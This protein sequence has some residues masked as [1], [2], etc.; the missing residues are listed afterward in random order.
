MRHLLITLLLCLFTFS[1]SAQTLYKAAQVEFEKEEYSK[2]VNLIK[3]SI[4]KEDLPYT[5][6]AAAFQLLQKS[7]YMQGLRNSPELDELLED[8]I[9]QNKTKPLQLISVAKIYTSV[10]PAEGFHKRNII[11]RST[12]SIQQD[13]LS[14]STKLAL[15]QLKKEQTYF[16]DLAELSVYFSQQE[17][18]LDPEKQEEYSYEYKKSTADY[19]ELLGIAQLTRLKILDL[20]SYNS[21]CAL[22]TLLLLE[23]NITQYD[24]AIQSYYWK[25]FTEIIQPSDSLTSTGAKQDFSFQTKGI[26]TPTEKLSKLPSYRLPE[27]L[28]DAQNDGERWRYGLKKLSDISAKERQ[29]S[30]FIQ[31][32]YYY[33]LDIKNRA[34]VL[35]E[36]SN[37]SIATLKQLAKEGHLESHWLLGTLYLERNQREKA[38]FYF[39]ESLKIKDH[40]AAKIALKQIIGNWGSF[41]YR[42][43][44]LKDS[45][46]KFIYRNSPYVD[47]TIR[48]VD[49]KK[50]F[51]SIHDHY[52]NLLGS[53]HSIP[54]N[55]TIDPHS[56]AKP[57]QRNIDF[58]RKFVLNSKQVRFPLDPNTEHQDKIVDIDLKLSRG[59]S[60]LVEAQMPNGNKTASFIYLPQNSITL[61]RLNSRV[62]IYVCDRFTG[63]PV[64]NK[65]V[66]LCAYQ[67]KKEDPDSF[68]E[69]NKRGS[70]Q[71]LIGRSDKDGLIFID[72]AQ[73][74][75]LET[76]KFWISVEDQ[77]SYDYCDIGSLKSHLLD[78]Y[79]TDER[80]DKSL[81]F[82][83]HSS[84]VATDKTHYKPGETLKF[85][86]WDRAIKYEP[87][88]TLQ[89][90]YKGD[91]LWQKR[92]EVQRRDQSISGEYKIPTNASSGEYRI[93]SDSGLK[94]YIGKAKE[95]SFIPKLAITK[96]PTKSDGKLILELCAQYPNGQ[97][98][99][100]AKTKIQLD[101]YAK[102]LVQNSPQEKWS[103]LYGQ[104]Y[105]HESKMLSSEAYSS[106]FRESLY[107][108]LYKGSF[109][110][111][112]QSQ[113]KYP[114]LLKKYYSVTL[115]E[116]GIA[117]IALD[118]SQIDFGDEL[119]AHAKIMLLSDS[120]NVYNETSSV[121]IASP[122][123]RYELRS[124]KNFYL[125]D[126]EIKITLHTTGQSSDEQHFDLSS[127]SSKLSFKIK[128]DSAVALQDL[129][130]G[131]YQFEGKT[132]FTVLD[133]NKSLSTSDKSLEIT[134]ENKTYKEGENAK[135]LI[136][137]KYKNAKVLFIT[138]PSYIGSYR[139]ENSDE[140]TEHSKLRLIQLDGFTKMLNLTVLN[141]DYP[142]IN[143][144]AILIK[145]GDFH[146][147][148]YNIPVPPSHKEIKVSLQSDKK[149]YKPGQKAKLKIK[150]QSHNNQ[151]ISSPITLSVYNKD[152][153]ESNRRPSRSQ[154][155]FKHLW[156]GLKTY[157]LN[158][159]TNTMSQGMWVNAVEGGLMSSL[160]STE[161]MAIPSFTNIDSEGF[162]N[163]IWKPLNI[164]KKEPK[165]DW[166]DV[167]DLAQDLQE[168]ARSTPQQSSKKQHRKSH[169]EN[170]YWN[171]NLIP[172]WRGEVTVEFTLP[173]TLS[174]WKIK[175]W[176]LDEELA[177]GEAELEIVTTKDLSIRTNPP[178]FLVEGD[179]ILYSANM[180]NS[181]DL[182]QEMTVDIK[183]SD[184]L[185]FINK[186]ETKRKVIIPAKTEAKVEWRLKAIKNGSAKVTINA[187]GKTD[188]DSIEE[189]FPIKAS[190][191]QKMISF[192]GSVEKT[193]PAKSF[194]FNVPNDKSELKITITPDLITTLVE[195]LPYLINH[196]HRNTE[197][198]LNS[199][200]STILI[201]DL[202][203][204]KE[205]KVAGSKDLYGQKTKDKQV[206]IEGE[207][208]D[209]PTYTSN[210]IFDKKHLDEL[211]KKG[212][213]KL[214]DMKNRGGGWP[215]FKG[216]KS[217]PY[218]TALI[219]NGLQKISSSQR[220]LSEHKGQERASIYLMNLFHY[221]SAD[222]NDE[223]AFITYLI[224]RAWIPPQFYEK[225]YK[226]RNR[227]STYSRCLIALI[228]DDAKA[229][230]ILAE[231]KEQVHINEELQ[232]AYLETNQKEYW[233]FYN[234]HIETQA[235]FL[236]LI[237]RIDPNSPLASQ[238]LR[239][240][241]NNRQ[242]S[243]HWSSTRSTALALDAII[244]Y[245]KIHK[246]ESSAK[247]VK[248]L[249][250]GKVYKTTKFKAG[251]F[252][253]EKL[254][255]KDLPKGKH[256]VEIRSTGE[257]HYRA[258]LSYFTQEKE[259]KKAGLDI[260]VTRQYFRITEDAKGKEIATEIK[261]TDTLQSADL[262]EVRLKIDSANDYEYILVSDPK[263]AS[264]E[265]V[266]SKSGYRYQELSFY[267]EFRHSKVNLYLENL[268]RG[269]HQ[270]NYRVRVENAGLF[271]A[272]PTLVE[273]MY[274][275]QIKAN[276]SNKIF[277]V[278]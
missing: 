207:Q 233:R 134:V 73:I 238:V 121:I 264:F 275:P 46:V 200:I 58:I 254:S 271:N 209:F 26:R 158:S 25:T 35:F 274:T 1:S 212:L 99:A 7:L 39:E 109:H 247:T 77:N 154:S 51:S 89:I 21:F 57:K 17:K 117:K 205:V 18:I 56:K 146:E 194:T 71:K 23:K 267:Q 223:N 43:A 188:S 175:A 206:L 27:S 45:K 100:N 78:D 79:Q 122:K 259:I 197:Q 196:P 276:S 187:Q 262:I 123:I 116:Q 256:T 255:I 191:K 168:T 270:L 150:V 160:A 14:P 193:H 11:Y 126:E 228:S 269:Q 143:I 163:L 147:V 137:S 253:A 125:H 107:P 94:F 152:F 278:R 54:I 181:L 241:L 251:H 118:T 216:G 74:S 120:N 266:N 33:S 114:S 85:K 81:F 30:L 141:N 231:L 180:Y 84:F 60:Y 232:T 159:S 234:D 229:K 48:Q 190:R 128:K 166:E 260:K 10:L 72:K 44:N 199:F 176:T 258:N 49:T 16:P 95:P 215:C 113:P 38:K 32:E 230:K 36:K 167:E 182:P 224:A 102:P 148:S 145:N 47:M 217:S 119:I 218:I 87:H 201:R 52:N 83:N 240:I 110:A 5:D 69:E 115:N 50:L 265:A 66:T 70:V 189:N 86:I 138:R 208:G 29:N 202:L 55:L 162:K 80:F 214:Y 53:E 61:K 139:H 153:D 165:D 135:I 248:I 76:H 178:R 235:S 144:A 239:Y 42:D 82:K 272:L 92:F 104:A 19:F 203:I 219:L 179:E 242:L 37:N 157:R 22:K 268:P 108:S 169:S 101:L 198:M 96:A 250:D 172:N 62:I 184:K 106:H 112:D 257:A 192:A 174:T 65:K 67:F 186:E 171:A 133:K 236:K 173:D 105:G 2:A 195:A 40:P 130:A 177:C 64:I 41:V 34:G 237:C 156:S 13:E 263:A 20:Q 213:D 142:N 225:L 161:N 15:L 183:I 31:A 111:Y 4:L 124:D 204:E 164:E 221:G 132:V 63:E 222:I 245:I 9:A 8:F 211:I 249:V 151:A 261:A 127:K 155:I 24:E 226:K 129:S 210:P 136:Q 68:D 140:E 88:E 98:I 91:L 252:L 6:F 59:K 28:E 90:Y 12:K 97:K 244:D 149:E 220:N 185:T 3:E 75:D 277:E 93:G 170:I 131:E 243:G 273:A 246:S 227:L 103:W